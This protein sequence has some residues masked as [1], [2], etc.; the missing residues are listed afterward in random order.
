MSK[1]LDVI[2][3][4]VDVLVPLDVEPDRVTENAS[5]GWDAYFFTTMPGKF[6]M[7]SADEDGTAGLFADRARGI[8]EPIAM[9]GTHAELSARI[10]QLLA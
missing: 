4:L 9:G 1:S 10:R 6:V 7:L 5:G 2:A 3:A 8:S